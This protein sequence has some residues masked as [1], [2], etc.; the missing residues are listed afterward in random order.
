MPNVPRYRT[1]IVLTLSAL[2]AAGIVGA[3]S[4]SGSSPFGQLAADGGEDAHVGDGAN[5][6]DSAQ[7]ADAQPGAK[8]K[9]IWNT[10]STQ[11]DCLP[12]EFPDAAAPYLTD[13]DVVCMFYA[14]HQQPGQCGYVCA[15]ATDP[16]CINAVIYDA[17]GGVVSSPS[18]YAPQPAAGQATDPAGAA[19]ICS[20]PGL[21]DQDC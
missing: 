3:C 9:T 17:D 16:A 13:K 11:A 6:A 19:L 2:T 21:S 14:L 7:A 5:G 15:Y 12:F 1:H 4:S 20:F 18:C 10:C 8:L